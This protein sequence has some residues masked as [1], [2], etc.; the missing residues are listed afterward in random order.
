MRSF[1]LGVV[2][3]IGSVGAYAQSGDYRVE[4]HGGGGGPFDDL[5]NGSDVLIGF[6]YTAGTAMNTVAGVCQPQRDGV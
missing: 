5:C 6:N 1:C 4:V 2:I 3:L